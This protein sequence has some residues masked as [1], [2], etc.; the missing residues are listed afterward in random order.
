MRLV[1]GVIIRPVLIAGL[2]QPKVMM[3]MVLKKGETTKVLACVA[4]DQRWEDCADSA[5]CR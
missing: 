1:H 3:R 2:L 5:A 4:V